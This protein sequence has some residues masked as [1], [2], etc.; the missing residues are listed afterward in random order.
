VLSLGRE[1]RAQT[2]R[3]K[4]NHEGRL[5]LEMRPMVGGRNRNV[6]PKK[7][8]FFFFGNQGRKRRRRLFQLRG[9]ATDITG[10]IVDFRA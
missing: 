7:N 10:N 9:E 3:V 8:T 5:V 2:A 4:G 6:E 1:E